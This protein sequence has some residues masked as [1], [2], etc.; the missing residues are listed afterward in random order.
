[1]PSDNSIPFDLPGFE[2]DQV[3]DYSELLVVQAHSIRTEGACPDCAQLSRRVHSYYTRSPRDLPS[4]GRKV[5]LVL[6][7]RRFRCQNTRCERKTFAERIP[8]IVPVHGQRTQRL[9]TT[10]HNVAFEL[11]AEAGARVSQHLNMAVSGDTLLRLLRNTKTNALPTPRVL[12][13]DDWAAKKGHIYGTILVDL[14][15]H[16][17]VDLLPDR[18]AET[19]AAWL[20]AHPGVEIICRDR[21]SDYAIGASL[22]A[23][24]AVQI[25]DRW[26]LLKNLGE[27]LQRMLYRHTQTL[28]AAAKQIHQE[29]NPPAAETEREVPPRVEQPAP[30]HRQQ[31]FEEVKQLAA[32]GD[33]Q[34]AIAR[35]LHIHRATVARYIHADELPRRR[36]PQTISSVAPYLAYLRQRLVAAPC[37]IHQLWEELQTQGY[38]GSYSSVRR[39]VRRFRPWD[40]RQRQTMDGPTP[41]PLSSRQAM[42]LLVR[43]TDQLTPEQVRYRAVLCD[44]S[45]TIATAYPLAQRFVTM[46]KLRQADELDIWLDDAQNSP[47]PA[48]R[49]FAVT[50]KRDYDAVKAALTFEWSSGQVEGQVNRLKVIKRIMYGRAKFD[51]LRLRVLHPP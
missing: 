34:R 38:T 47:I 30:P 21:A 9:T 12:G 15:Q 32:Q 50:L 43:E 40:G 33:S 13:V 3:D 51:L 19:L 22:G 45:P 37:T 6:G 42:W 41:R 27:A 49:N 48:L 18:E 1:M 16:Q 4:S 17:A 36:P 24:N 23:P 5:R 46:V 2:I 11:S 29:I 44:L 7:V 35:Q 39:T 28:R 26:H 25:A 14:E 20:K 8:H 31:V 10:L